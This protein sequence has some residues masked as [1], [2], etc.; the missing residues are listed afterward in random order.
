[1]VDKEGSTDIDLILFNLEP[2]MGKE[3]NL[4]DVLKQ[5]ISSVSS[6]AIIERIQQTQARALGL[7]RGIHNTGTRVMS[8][9]QA[10]DGR[11][12][13]PTQSDTII[14]F[15]TVS[16]VEGGIQKKGVYVVT[17]TIEIDGSRHVRITTLPSQSLKEAQHTFDCGSMDHPDA[18]QIISKSVGKPTAWVVRVE[19]TDGLVSSLYPEGLESPHN[20]P[21]GTMLFGGRRHRRVNGALVAISGTVHQVHSGKHRDAIVLQPGDEAVPKR[22]TVR[23]ITDNTA[24][25]RQDAPQ[26][27]DVIKG[28]ARMVDGKLHLATVNP[29]DAISSDRIIQNDRE[30][31]QLFDSS[32]SELVNLFREE[33]AVTFEERAMNWTER[34]QQ[35][36]RII[37]EL[38]TLPLTD[39]EGKK[40]RDMLP[41][42]VKKPPSV[43]MS[44]FRLPHIRSDGD[45]IVEATG[46]VLDSGRLPQVKG[47]EIETESQPYLTD[48]LRRDSRVE[49]VDTY[50]EAWH[51]AVIPTD[52]SSSSPF[53]ESTTR[54]GAQH[55]L[56]DILTNGLVYDEQRPPTADVL[57]L[58]GETVEDQEAKAAFVMNSLADAIQTRGERLNAGENPNDEVLILSEMINHLGSPLD[59][60]R[61]V[62]ILFHLAE[63][64]RGDRLERGNLGKKRELQQLAHNLFKRSI[65]MLAETIKTG[66]LQEHTGRSVDPLIYYGNDI[67]V[68]RKELVDE[69]IVFKPLD[70]VILAVRSAEQGVV[71]RDR[72]L[73]EV[74]VEIGTRTGR[75]AVL[76]GEVSSSATQQIALPQREPG[77]Q[78]SA[79][80]SG[81]S[82]FEVFEKQDPDVD[83]L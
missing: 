20:I 38:R 32:Y 77:A 29:S 51:R 40:L 54:Q 72:E 21:Q 50:T 11:Y 2:T 79:E 71:R 78:L 10:E 61:R 26:V 14:P 81:G 41:F 39:S 44:F 43:D 64:C 60:Q 52:E 82:L 16:H 15:D 36:R 49:S 75:A 63:I 58:L 65:T 1:M 18:V 45:E 34:Y 66:V 9:P 6:E 69:G 55:R 12:F 47:L 35:A 80:P 23:I 70:D 57:S 73:A 5:N 83:D 28:T 67:A 7:E 56:L 48:T 37:A 27:G 74:R 8:L 53:L 46:K 3:K 59:E 19:D 31:R 42:F 4:P 24:L 30:L 17:G 22:E 76:E 13:F 68:W 33:V 62:K 25:F